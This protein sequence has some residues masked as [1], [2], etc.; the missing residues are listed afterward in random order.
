MIKRY[1]LGR[2][3]RSS[4]GTPAIT[5]QPDGRYVLFAD[6]QHEMELMRLEAEIWR[7]R[8]IR[9]EKLGADVLKSGLGE[10]NG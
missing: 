1:D 10:I 3:Y 8:T 2:E 6:H 7:N 5:E 9:A 4:V